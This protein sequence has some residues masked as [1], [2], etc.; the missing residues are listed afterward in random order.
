MQWCK[1]QKHSGGPTPAQPLKKTADSERG[2]EGLAKMSADAPPVFFN[3]LY[4]DFLL[5]LPIRKSISID[6]TP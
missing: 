6:M 1:K 5:K 2:R 4:T 3:S